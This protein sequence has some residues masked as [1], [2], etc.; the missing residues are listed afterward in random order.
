M[1]PTIIFTMTN[2]TFYIDSIE[3][4]FDYKTMSVT[5]LHLIFDPSDVQMLP[6]ASGIMKNIYSF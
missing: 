5:F 1:P 4:Q 2:M 6:R 3:R